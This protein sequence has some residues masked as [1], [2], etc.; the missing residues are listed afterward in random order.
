MDNPTTY[1]LLTYH[2]A[3]KRRVYINKIIPF[4]LLH[5]LEEKGWRQVQGSAW[6]AFESTMGMFRL[7]EL[8][9]DEIYLTFEKTK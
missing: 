6:P 8:L 9:S 5:C 1:H 7:I 4:K 2:I 3:K